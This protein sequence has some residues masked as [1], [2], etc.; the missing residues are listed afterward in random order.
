MTAAKR[1]SR[2]SRGSKIRSE[3]PG[4]AKT[5]E[6]RNCA[7][8]SSATVRSGPVSQI[9][10]G[11]PEP[12]DACAYR[13]QPYHTTLP[14]PS[15]GQRFAGAAADQCRCVPPGEAGD[16]A[17]GDGGQV[18]DGPVEQ[19]GGGHLRAGLVAGGGGQGADQSEFGDSEAAGGEGQYRQQ[20]DEREGG[21]G[22]LRGTR[23][24]GRAQPAQPGQQEEPQGEVARRGGGG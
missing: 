14:G 4:V 22:G 18:G 21:E 24:R 19:H 1:S 10:P 6:P 9:S 11:K 12:P 13:R 23:A 15:A 5:R 17:E 20:P 7:L 8:P 2:S 16:R 3:P